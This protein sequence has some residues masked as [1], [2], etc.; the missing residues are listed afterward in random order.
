MYKYIPTNVKNKYQMLN[1]MIYVQLHF[2]RY[3][4]DLRLIIIHVQRLGQD[5]ILIHQ[6]EL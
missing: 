5:Q 4:E 6:T 1:K 2:N 3:T